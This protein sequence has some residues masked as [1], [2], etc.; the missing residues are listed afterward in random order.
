MTSITS[1]KQLLCEATT[2]AMMADFT[3]ICIYQFHSMYIIK[4]LSSCHHGDRSS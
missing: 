4:Q 2:M 1:A 3:F